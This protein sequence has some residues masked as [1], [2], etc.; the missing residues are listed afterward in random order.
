MVEILEHGSKTKLNVNINFSIFFNYL[1]EII[2]WWVI[3]V[4]YIFGAVTS[5]LCA[6]FQAKVAFV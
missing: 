2:K 5:T 4:V 1:T 3:Y 6:P